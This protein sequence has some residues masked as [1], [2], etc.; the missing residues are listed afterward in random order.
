MADAAD[1][2]AWRRDHSNLVRVYDRR[3]AE[4]FIFFFLKN[5][6]P[7]DFSPLPLPDPLPISGRRR[8]TG[9]RRRPAGAAPRPRVNRL[10]RHELQVPADLRRRPADAA[11]PGPPDRVAR[12]DRAGQ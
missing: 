1:E 8:G 3:Y 11:H 7:T 2:V 12:P 10:P 9:R 4:F 6:P 5:P